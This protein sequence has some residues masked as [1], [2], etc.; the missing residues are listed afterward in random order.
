MS[1]EHSSSIAFFDVDGT[2]VDGVVGLY[3]SLRL[4]QHKVMKKRRVLQAIYFSIADLVVRQD[5]EA[6]YHIAMKDMAGWPL[7]RIYELG[8]LSWERDSKPRMYQEGLEK[9]RE[10]QRSGHRV[11]LMSSAPY[12]VLDMMAQ[13][14]G[15]DDAYGVGPEAVDGILINQLRTPLCYG[16]GKVHYAHVA[17]KKYDIP[18]SQCYFYSNDA[19]DLPLLY[20]VGH[21]CAVNP[22]KALQKIAAERSWKVVHWKR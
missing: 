16:D 6:I 12:M 18:L 8:K 2:L 11:I 13:D 9:I 19:V 3:A 1:S 7:A 15:L 14:L 5:V 10:H 4:V 21:P 20:K 22:D 17:S